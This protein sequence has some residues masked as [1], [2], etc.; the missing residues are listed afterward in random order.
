MFVFSLR[1]DFIYFSI[2][3]LIFSL[4]LVIYDSDYL[5]FPFFFLLTTTHF[6]ISREGDDVSI[7]C[8]FSLFSHSHDR[9]IWQ[10]MGRLFSSQKSKTKVRFSS[11]YQIK[12]IQFQIPDVS[13]FAIRSVASLHF[14]PSSN[15]FDS[16]N[17]SSSQISLSFFSS[18]YS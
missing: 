18:F 5:T 13:K 16:F 3:K 6:I 8:R 4:S 12:S 11:G 7:F 2:S 9:H 14:S 15:R 1:I 10:Y 17:G